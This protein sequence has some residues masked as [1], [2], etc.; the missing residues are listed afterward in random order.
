MQN[1][2]SSLG[3]GQPAPGTPAADA[4]GTVFHLDL[5]MDAATLHLPFLTGAK[6]LPDGRL[7]PDSGTPEVTL[8]MPKIKLSFAQTAGG[9]GT[10]PLFTIGLDSWA[11]HDIDDPAGAGYG[12]P[13]RMNPSYALL[14]PADWF[15]F[16][17]ASVLVDLSGTAT[18]PELM[19]KFGI[20]EDFRGLYL[21]DVRVFLQP[22]GATGLAFDVSA[23]E[24]LIG[25]GPE[26]G[27]SGI[28]GLDVVKPDSPQAGTV[29]VYDDFG[30][31]IRRVE[32]PDSPGPGPAPVLV[33]D[34]TPVPASPKWVVDV[35][36][37]QPPYNISVDGQVQ[38]ST[39]VAVTIPVG[40]KTKTVEVVITDVH[41]AQ[42]RHATFPLI[43]TAGSLTAPQGSVPGAAS[44]ST[45]P[46]W[47]EGRLDGG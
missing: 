36:G 9:P 7:A 16:G 12:E 6:L 44:Y 25:I 40:S 21:P 37:G 43:L 34:P 32:I 19:A 38:T 11:A 13:L 28:F 2:L 41:T 1:L 18:P 4:P 27:V 22:G 33:V 46:T 26:G 5:L 29:T 39:A 8:V 31:M 15:G 35:T 47:I 45:C 14:G 23:R 20:G 10:D 42:Q 3:Q 17:F 24:L 30:T